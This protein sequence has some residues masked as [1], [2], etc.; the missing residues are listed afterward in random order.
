M[1]TKHLICIAVLTA[2]ALGF[3]IDLRSV[4]D[5]GE[6]PSTFPMFLLPQI[7]LNLDTLLIS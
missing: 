3:G 1:Q 2:I 5:K 6:L 7:P 4:G